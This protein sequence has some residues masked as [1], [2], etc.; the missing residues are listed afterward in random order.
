MAE[1]TL[2]DYVGYIFSEIVRARDIAD[3]ESKRIALIYAQDQIMQYFSVP[4]FKIPEM[5]LTIPVLI[6]GARFSTTVNFIMSKGDFK[7]FITSKLT[8]IIRSITLKRRDFNIFVVDRRI[9]GGENKRILKADISEGSID[10]FFD[11]LESNQDPS[12]PDNI[13]QEK[14]Y[15]IFTQRIQEARLAEE[16]KKHFP[17]NELFKQTLI[18]V[19]EKVKQNT[20]VSQTKITN[21]LVNPETNVVKNGSNENSVFIVKAK[22]TEEGIFIKTIRDKDTGEEKQITEFE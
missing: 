9:L 4:R 18:E 11:L 2:S 19:T 6:S 13:I 5:E 17:N 10:E 20:I 14:W 15:D 7:T 22:I 12:Q 21:L 8:N 1:I 16:Y 3:R